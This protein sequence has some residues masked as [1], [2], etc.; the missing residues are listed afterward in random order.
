VT[1]VHDDSARRDIP[2]LMA[3]LATVSLWGS[4]FVG[5]R[6]ASHSLTPGS[7]ALGRL[8]VSSALLTA[9][10]LL[11]REQ[12]P[13]RR[14]FAPIVVFG[15]LF[16]GAYSITLNTAERHIDAGSSA[17]VVSTGPLLIALLAG[18]AL[19]EGFPRGLLLGSAV[20]LAGCVVIGAATRGTGGSSHPALALLAVATLTYATAVVIQ[21][22][23]LRRASPFQVTWLG[24]LAA[25]VLCS[26]AAPSLFSQA[27]DPP[28]LVWL[29]Y[30]GAMPTALGFATWSFAL[31]RGSAGRVAALNYLIPVVAIVLAW[32]YLGE[33]PPALA[34]GGG[35]LCLA[36]VFL[37]RRPGSVKR[38]LVA[39]RGTGAAASA[40]DAAAWHA[41]HPFL[42]EKT[43]R[44]D[45]WFQV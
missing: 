38:R 35:A 14:S 18:I 43:D 7:I 19:R 5:I 41:L 15:V 12:L 34:V 40:R 10:A 31:S 30:L 1:D 25:T 4:A 22:S 2:A 28:A 42:G 37:A 45:E 11:R 23:A 26:P 27:N 39:H 33:R 20:A 9:I 6:A 24:C 29:V 17:M 44:T 16:L 32:G 3:G 21:K 8:L 13:E 36:G